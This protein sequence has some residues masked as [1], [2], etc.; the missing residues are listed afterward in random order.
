MHNKFFSKLQIYG[1]FNY[2]SCNSFNFYK[3]YF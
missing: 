3:F 1:N 2:I